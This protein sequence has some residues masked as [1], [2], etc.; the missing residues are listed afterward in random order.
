VEKRFGTF[1]G[2]EMVTNQVALAGAVAA[3]ERLCQWENWETEFSLE[4]DSVEII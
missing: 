4:E 1:A 2:E 3:D